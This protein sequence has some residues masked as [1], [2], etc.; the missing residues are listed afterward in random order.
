MQLKFKTN[1]SVRKTLHQIIMNI[2]INQKHDCTSRSKPHDLRYKTLVQCEE[3]L[4]LINHG[5]NPGV[6]V[7]DD[8]I[9]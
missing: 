5:D 9:F 6:R 7:L 1:Y 8:R 4:L 3:S 2:F